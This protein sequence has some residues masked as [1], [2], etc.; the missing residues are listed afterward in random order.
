MS[1]TDNTELG[2]STAKGTVLMIFP[3]M[4]FT[5][6]QFV[7]RFTTDRL[8]DFR[9]FETKDCHALHVEN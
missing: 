3:F 1:V 6:A 8:V 7:K 5:T 9:T 2:T 4:V